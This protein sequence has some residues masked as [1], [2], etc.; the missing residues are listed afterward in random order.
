M[1]LAGDERLLHVGK[2]SADQNRGTAEVIIEDNL[3]SKI[4]TRHRNRSLLW[5]RKD[6]T[7]LCGTVA[8]LFPA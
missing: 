4:G 8:I 1:R 6:A 5:G 2:G 3:I 7:V